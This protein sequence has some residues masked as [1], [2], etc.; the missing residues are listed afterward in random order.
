[1]SVGAQG[2]LG[3]FVGS[4]KSIKNGLIKLDKNYEFSIG[5]GFKLFNQNGLEVGG[6]RI[7][8]II[9]GCA[10]IKDAK[11]GYRVNITSSNFYFS[12]KKLKVD[13]FYN[14]NKNGVLS[15]TYS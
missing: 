4:V 7:D 2:N 8:K 3:I 11:V 13:T 9:D 6:G 1:M 15:I 14:L 5:E 12:E 10:E